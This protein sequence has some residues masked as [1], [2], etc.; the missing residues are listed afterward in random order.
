MVQRLRWEQAQSH[1]KEHWQSISN[2]INNTGE[3]RLT[4]YQWRA[5]NL[6]Y[7]IK[8]AFQADNFTFKKFRILELGS[9]PVGVVSAIEEAKERVAIDPLCNFYSSQEA[10]IQCRSNEVKYLN[11][12][13]EDLAFDDKYFDL[14]LIENVIDHVQDSCRVM[15][16]ISRVLK[17][18]GILYLTVNLHPPIGFV[19]H[20]IASKL[21]IDKGHPHSFTRGRIR[22]FLNEYG[23]EIARDEWENYWQCRLNDLKSD[24]YKRKLKALSGLS[25]FLYTSVCR[26]S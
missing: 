15:K 23:F 1:E 4:W 17:S 19:L 10:L 24:S 26:N 12:R 2:Q 18:S 13:G 25:E 5:K 20:R 22:R 6:L 11:A 9:G 3:G 21:Q 14:V 8:K 7:N 16:E